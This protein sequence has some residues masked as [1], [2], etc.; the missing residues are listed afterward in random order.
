MMEFIILFVLFGGAFWLY[1][2]AVEVKAKKQDA[3]YERLVE[4]MNIIDG[5]NI[6][7]F[8]QLQ[9]ALYELEKEIRGEE[10]EI[11]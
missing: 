9:D 7:R 8:T 3:Q 2:H 6:S 11:D 4:I 10:G 5:Y 1:S